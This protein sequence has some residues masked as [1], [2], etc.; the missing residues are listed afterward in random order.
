GKGGT[1]RKGVEGGDD[2]R[3]GDGDGEL[4]V[5]L[6]TEAADEGG[7]HEDG[8]EHQRDGDDGTGD[9]V[10]GPAGGFR[11]FQ[12]QAEVGLDIFHDDDGVIHHDADGQYQAKEREV[13]DGKAQRVH[14]GKRPHQR[15]GHGGQ[16]DQGSAP[17]L[18]K[19]H[20]DDDHKPNGF[21]QGRDDGSDGA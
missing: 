8:A 15:Y 10:H 7:G 17:R 2:G 5:E 9:F 14:H 11:R 18:E 4:F 16:G 21:E 12:A 13:V 1:E 3:D 19:E 6:P 20:D